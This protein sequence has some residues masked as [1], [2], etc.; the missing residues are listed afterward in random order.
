MGHLV[1]AAVLIVVAAVLWRSRHPL[2]LLGLQT[3][4]PDLGVLH[5]LLL[6][7]RGHVGAEGLQGV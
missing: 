5:H 4:E 6:L 1:V 3:E 7:V 2:N